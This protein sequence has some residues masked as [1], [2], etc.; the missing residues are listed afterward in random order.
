MAL[1]VNDTFISENLMAFC[2]GNMSDCHINCLNCVYFDIWMLK[3]V[4]M[5]LHSRRSYKGVSGPAG[6]AEDP[7]GL[8][9][10]RDAGATSGPA[11]G[12]W[13]PWKEVWSRPF[14][15]GPCRVGP[16]VRSATGTGCCKRKHHPSAE[17]NNTD[18]HPS[19]P[20]LVNNGWRRA[21]RHDLWPSG[22]G[23]KTETAT[24]SPQ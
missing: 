11:V 8:P 17:Q 10:R 5:S 7:A 1:S 12:T 18:P 21:C 19:E 24:R 3:L 15:R 13:V 6:G 23:H 9:G 4:N 2:V 16:G 22:P 14:Q 20:V